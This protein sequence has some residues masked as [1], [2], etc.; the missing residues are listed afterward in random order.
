MTFLANNP[1]SGIDDALSS[2]GLGTVDVSE[3]TN[4]VKKIV[5]ERVDFIK[6][7]GER[8]VGGLMGIAMKELKGKADGKIIRDLL[9]V[10]VQRVL[11]A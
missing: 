10:E 4:I 8:A 7:Q 5:N 9:I 3:L 1:Q 11:S 6:E 2:T